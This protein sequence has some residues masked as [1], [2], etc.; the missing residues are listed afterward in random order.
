MS[1]CAPV[2]LSR[3]WRQRRRL[4]RD[5]RAFLLLKLRRSR[6]LV[7]CSFF[8]HRIQVNH[9]GALI[10]TANERRRV[11][12]WQT[13]HSTPVFLS[14]GQGSIHKTFFL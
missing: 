12:Q 6:A 1:F 11:G 3:H 2:S 4:V 7:L 9:W 5:P 8:I 10:V 13:V 14:S